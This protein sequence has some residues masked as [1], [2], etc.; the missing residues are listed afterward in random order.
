MLH[1][2]TKHE[3][4]TSDWNFAKRPLRLSAKNSS[5]QNQQKRN[6]LSLG[7]KKYPN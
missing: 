3:N 6:S 4:S 1:I 5:R 7:L 2:R